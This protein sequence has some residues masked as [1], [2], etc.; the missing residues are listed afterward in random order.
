MKKFII[1]VLILTVISLGNAA[2]TVPVEDAVKVSKNFLSERIGSTKAQSKTLTLVHTEYA[3]DGTP[4]YYRFQVDNKGYVIVSA[5]D[6]EIPI[7]AYSLEGNYDARTGAVY[8]CD[9]YK[10]HL[11]QLLQNPKA[12]MEANKNWE[13][14]LNDHFQIRDRKG[15]PAVEP[16]ITTQWTQETYYNT[17]CPVNPNANYDWDK[18]TPVGCVALSMANIMYY[19]RYPSSGFGGVTYIPKEYDDNGNLIYTYPVQ[20]VNFGSSYYDYNAMT[21]SLDQ[22]DGELAELIYHCGVSVRMG[23]G[24]EGS[25]SQSEKALESLQNFFHYSPLAQF[26]NID[27]IVTS[28]SLL[29]K[30]V[31]MIK[32]EIDARRPVFFSGANQNA[33]GHAWIIDGYTTIDSA[34]YFHVNWGW[35]G[36][37]NGFFLI[38]N[39]NT[40]SYGNFNMSGSESVMVNL[41]PGDNDA[42]AKPATSEARITASL[43]TISDGAG[44]VKYAQN[45]NRRWVIACPNA[46]SYTFDF[47]KLKLKTGDKVTIYNGGTENAGIKKEY[48]GNYLMAACSD[49]VSIDGSVH[50]DYF[51]EPLPPPITVTKDSVLIIFTS[52]ATS[53]TD[54]GF[55]LNYKVNSYNIGRCAEFTNVTNNPH[56]ILTDKANN[57]TD[58]EPYRA[59]TVCKWTFRIPNSSGYTFAFNKFD[60]KEGDFIDFYDYTSHSNPTFIARYDNTNIP[61][62]AITIYSSQVRVH[63]VSD[64]WQQGNGFELEYYQITGIDDHSG[65]EDVCIYPNPATTDVNICIKTDNAQTIN[66]QIIDLTGKV[67]YGDRFDHN[68]GEQVY[69]IPVNSLAEGIYFLHLQSQQGKMIYKFIVQ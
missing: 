59:A 12:D 26:K 32:E 35:A 1:L 25:A 40:A 41:Y 19:Y 56:G 33:G 23:Y 15:A 18:R 16:L 29:Y 11:T 66:A 2:N 4:L 55:V 43:G 60:L 37:G 42:C 58:N 38:N 20:S 27:D 65:L 13:Y 30:W 6:L 54:Y 69:R 5:T 45:S 34:T 9:K 44:N 49:Y 48:S 36:E 52:T 8:L 67:V 50:G 17:Y 62:D 68:G 57:A 53:E 31:D 24:A 64:N 10:A 46:N 14:Y 63:F 21:N 39:Q 51:G 28:G 22:Y 61:T 7:L 47:A 3:E